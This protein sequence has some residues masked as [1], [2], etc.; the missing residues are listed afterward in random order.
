MYILL[1][2]CSLTPSWKSIICVLQAQLWLLMTNPDNPAC[3][4]SLQLSRF[5]SSHVLCSESQPHSLS[6]WNYIKTFPAFFSYKI[7]LIMNET[8]TL[9]DTQMHSQ[10]FISPNSF[11]KKIKNSSRNHCANVVF[12]WNVESE[13]DIFIVQQMV[14]RNMSL[15]Q[16]SIL[17]SSSCFFLW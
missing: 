4:A 1:N 13:R 14:P 11:E 6:Q 3:F 7:L 9:L 16:K 8:K 17:S 2:M 10:I 5:F 15:L 12:M